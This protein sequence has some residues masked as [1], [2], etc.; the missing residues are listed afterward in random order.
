MGGGGGAK[1]RGLTPLPGEK[2]GQEG[3]GRWLRPQRGVAG[4]AA[5]GGASVDVRDPPVA[6]RRVADLRLQ[7]GCIVALHLADARHLGIETE[8][9]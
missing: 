2:R 3:V 9:N 4:A 5:Q 7:Q 6:V 8:T 1:E